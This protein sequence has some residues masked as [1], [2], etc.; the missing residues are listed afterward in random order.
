MSQHNQNESDYK[1]IALM[2]TDSHLHHVFSSSDHTLSTKLDQAQ[3]IDLHGFEWNDD[4]NEHFIDCIV[5]FKGHIPSSRSVMN[6][7]MDIR[8]SFMEYVRKV[9]PNLIYNPDWQDL[10]KGL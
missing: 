3:L 10:Q 1:G 4:D 7:W 2:P 5:K 9:R 6:K 8:I